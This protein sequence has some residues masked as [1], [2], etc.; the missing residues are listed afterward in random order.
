MTE[1][2]WLHATD[3]QP[4]LRVVLVEDYRTSGRKLRLF[5]VACCRRIWGLMMDESC[6]QVVEVAERYADGM[7]T[8]EERRAADAAGRPVPD[9]PRHRSYPAYAALWACHDASHPPASHAAIQAASIAVVIVSTLGGVPDDP[10]QVAQAALGERA[11]QAGLLRDIL[12]LS[13]FRPLPT[14]DPDW[15]AWR[16]GLVRELAKA[17]YEERSLPEGTLDPA[18]LAILADAL[19]EA[20]CTDGELLGHLRGPGP[21]VRGCWVVDLLT[22]RA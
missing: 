21:H 17:V 18:R 12:G 19:E 13:M 1:G 14:I 2:E 16:R 9:A 10:A 8:E 22:G 3:P 4:M 20:G 11:A 15:L 5:C 6:R 7:A